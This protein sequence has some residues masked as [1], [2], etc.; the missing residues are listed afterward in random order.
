MRSALLVMLVAALL[1][2]TACN[3][4]DLPG[5]AKIDVDTPELRLMKKSAG[6]EDCVPGSAG[7]VDGGLPHLTLPCLG[8]GPDVDTST[9]RGPMVVN[10]WASWC[11]PCRTELPI[12]QHFYEQYG[13]QVAVLGIDWQDPQPKAALELAAS[14]GVTYPLLADPQDDL[15]GAAPLPNLRGLPF[16]AFVDADGKVVH[17]EFVAITSEKQLVDLVAKNLRV[18]L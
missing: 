16:V 13:D 11:G 14:S 7:P 6:V 12:Y 1:P 9:L 5:P 15:S 4:G 2:L 18:A 17:Q 10:V 8:G 3:Q